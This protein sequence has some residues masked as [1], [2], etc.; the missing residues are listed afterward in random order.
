MKRL[1]VLAAALSIIPAVHA[2][3]KVEQIDYHGWMGAYRISN[4]TVDLVVV[5]QV[6]RVMRY[7]YLGQANMLWENAALA[8]KPPVAGQWNNY[9]GDKMWPAPQ[10]D[11]NWPPDPA[12]DGAPWTAEPL[13]SGLRLTSPVGARAKIQF[14]RDITLQSTG[15][16]VSFHNL[17]K[18][19]GPAHLLSPWQI[20]QLDDPFSVFL[21]TLPTP[22]MTNGW[23][24]LQGPHV[25]SA[26]HHIQPGGIQLSRSNVAY[27]FGAFSDSGEITASKGSVVFH[28]QTKTYPRLNYPD[29]GSAMEVF[30]NAGADKYAELELLGP[31]TRMDNGEAAVLDTTW[32]LTQGQ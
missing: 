3:V 17:M 31:L 4:D 22:Q 9:G 7:G 29:G 14:V 12:I 26:V 30:L 11:W 1:P 27:K 25:D 16:N 8:G 32:R 19:Q 10:R 20:T 24:L 21:P 28:M 15:T 5:P 2:Q 13:P 18:N 6:G 23:R